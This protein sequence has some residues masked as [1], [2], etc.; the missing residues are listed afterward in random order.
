AVDAIGSGV[1]TTSRG[2]YKRM[3]ASG[4]E[5]VANDRIAILRGGRSVQRRVRLHAEDALHFDHR[6]MMVIDGRV[7]YVGGTGIEDHFADGR[8]ADAMCRVTGPIVSQVQLAFLTSWA[9]DGGPHPPDLD[10]LF[11]DEGGLPPAA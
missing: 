10:G 4:I 6:K 2:L 8:F 1:D 7:A 5:I 11:L 9:K 3:R